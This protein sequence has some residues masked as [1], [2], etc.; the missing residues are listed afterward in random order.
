MT[1]DFQYDGDDVI[2]EIG[3]Y[4]LGA[5]Y[6]RSMD[7]DDPF[8]RMSEV[9]EYYHNDGLGSVVALTDQVGSVQDSYIFDPFGFSTNIGSSSNSFQYTGRENDTT[10]LHYYRARYYSP[11]FQRFLSEDL[12]WLFGQHDNFYAYV[13]NNPVNLIDPMGLQFRLPDFFSGTF[14]FTIPTRWTGEWVSWSFTATVDRYGRIYVSP[15]GPG[16][17]RAPEDISGAVTAN[18]IFQKCKPTPEQLSNF[19][20]AHGITGALGNGGGGNII[21]SPGNGSAWGVGLLTKQGG[22]NYSYTYLWKDTEVS[23]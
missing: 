3:N 1:T 11:T 7:I 19:L 18:W 20:T 22:A 23:W 15:W 14:S 5:T 12:L 9:N 21:I 13:G 4:S 16:V 2:S 10:N 6:L 17:G 8:I